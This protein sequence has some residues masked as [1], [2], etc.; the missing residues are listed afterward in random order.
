MTTMLPAHPFHPG[1]KRLLGAGP[2]PVHPRVVAAMALPQ[3]GHLDPEFLTLMEDTQ[4][5]L[6]QLFGS[7]EAF[8]LAVSTT[9]SGGMEAVLAS[10]IEPGDEVLVGVTGYFGGR[11]AEMATR[12]GATVH[13]LVR[14]WGEVVSTEEVATT[15]DRH[16]AIRLVALVHAETSTGAA[17][18]L[19]EIGALCRARGV[20]L[21]VDTVTSLGGM[22]FA[23]D[24]WDIDAA[25]SASQKCLSAPPGLAP[26]A[27]GPRALARLRER[28]QPVRSW[29]LD[30]SLLAAYWG[31]GQRAYHHTAPILMNYALHE[32]LALVFE[33]G[34]EER[35]ARHRKM[36]QALLA[37]LAELG[38]VPHVAAE[39][40]LAMLNALR[41]PEGLDEAALRRRLLLDHGIEIGGGLGELAGRIW[42]IG[43]MGEGARAE[44]VRAV[45][46]AIEELLWRAGRVDRLGRGLEAVSQVL[47]SPAA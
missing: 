3:V 18:P 2:S 34:L 42:R 28:R 25:W 17:Q 22:P 7:E 26:V 15:L 8:T 32:A 41:L 44:Q 29:Y 12:H 43:L 19:A 47:A 9:G 21:A 10:L 30:L 27:L 40:R 39:H 23:L 11:I 4:R 38:M 36:S 45:V 35:F 20:L 31:T 6:R 5:L 37:G 33:E 14:P 13:R 16:P 24:A 1:T 46:A